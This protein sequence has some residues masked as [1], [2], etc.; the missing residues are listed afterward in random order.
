[1]TD[2]IQPPFGASSQQGAQSLLTHDEIRRDTERIA[3]ELARLSNGTDPFAAAVRATRMPMIVTD[4]RQ[5]DNP[6]VFAND[7]FCR[8]TGYAREEIIGRN[9]RFLQG[10]GTDPAVVARIRSA[11]ADRQPIEADI[12]NYRKSGEKFWN[13]LLLAPV[14]DAGGAVAYFFA[15]QVDVTPERE[16]LAG[17]ESRNAA[18]M[19]EIADR[20]RALQESEA[21]FRHMADSAPA[22]IWMTNADG[23]ISFA[24]MHYHHVFGCVPAEVLGDG[25]NRLVLPEDLS[26]YLD[27]FQAAFR[28]RV[29]FRSETRVRDKAGEIR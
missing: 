23:R 12:L 19:A 29:A 17:L 10:P 2:R 3:V 6:V 11:V 16:R 13:R 15:S 4:P 8:L 20:V 14:R 25:W 27:C 26:R 7:S 5:S 18:L 21:R 9:C 24:N 1:M 22:L 28:E